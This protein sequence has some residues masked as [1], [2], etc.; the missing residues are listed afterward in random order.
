ML[1]AF[2]K[3]FHEPNNFKW[4][5]F[6]SATKHADVKEQTI[7]LQKQCMYLNG[8]AGKLLA[9]RT[10]VYELMV[11]AYVGNET[12]LFSLTDCCTAIW[13]CKWK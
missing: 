13:C 10:N 7:L 5:N 3:T 2:D 4:R 12:Y 9:L 1:K 11:C 8:S 6:F